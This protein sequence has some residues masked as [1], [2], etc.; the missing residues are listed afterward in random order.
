MCG[1]RKGEI[2][3]RL[4]GYE[5]QVTARLPRSPR[6]ASRALAMVFADMI[7]GGPARARATGSPRVH[8]RAARRPTI[9]R[10]WA[11][12]WTPRATCSNADRGATARLDMRAQWRARLAAAA[13]VEGGAPATNGGARR[14]LPRLPD[15]DPADARNPRALDRPRPGTSSSNLDDAITSRAARRGRARDRRAA[16]WSSARRGR[17]LRQHRCSRGGRPHGVPGGPLEPSSLGSLPQAARHRRPPLTR[18][19]DGRAGFAPGGRRERRA[20]RSSNARVAPSCALR[21]RRVAGVPLPCH[22]E[23]GGEVRARAPRSQQSRTGRAVAARARLLRVERGLRRRSPRTPKDTLIALSCSPRRARTSLSAAP[24]VRGSTGSDRSSTYE[25]SAG[26]PRR[27]AASRRARRATC[28]GTAAIAVAR[29]RL[30][31]KAREKRLRETM[32]ARTPGLPPPPPISL[33][34]GSIRERRRSSTLA[35]VAGASLAVRRSTATTTS[36]RARARESRRR[37]V[38]RP[39]RRSPAEVVSATLVDAPITRTRTDA[40]C[41]SCSAQDSF[42]AARRQLQGCVTGSRPSGTKTTARGGPLRQASQ[43]RP[44]ARAARPGDAEP[45]A[46]MGRGAHEKT[47]SAR[48]AGAR[49]CRAARS[50]TPTINDEAV[51]EEIER[52]L[53]SGVARAT[54]IASTTHHLGD[55]MHAGLPAPSGPAR[56]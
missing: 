11:S 54:A 15:G 16:L 7:L 31:R 39:R 48:A 42:L 37:G 5:I 8:V 21:A 2:A 55:G 22:A 10:S 23:R 51:P 38:G 30:R 46:R 27:S 6:R 13:V 9:D 29:R 53:S 17:R 26:V 40:K 45:V 36:E 20:E 33:V 56:A 19:P 1:D 24:G 32:S 25:P 12:W 35:S 41:A 47:S 52:R 34:E 14:H 43:R 50:R 3:R 18:P 28:A 4:G 44:A 49:S